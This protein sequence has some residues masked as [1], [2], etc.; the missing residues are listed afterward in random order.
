MFVSESNVFSLF[1]SPPHKETESMAIGEGICDVGVEENGNTSVDVTSSGTFSHWTLDFLAGLKW[2]LFL[3]Q[4]IRISIEVWIVRVFFKVI[5]GSWGLCYLQMLLAFFGR[6]AA[7]RAEK[8]LFWGF[9]FLF[10]RRRIWNS[11]YFFPLLGFVRMGV[12]AYLATELRIAWEQS[13]HNAVAGKQSLRGCR[14]ACCPAPEQ[15]TQVHTSE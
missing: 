11:C 8:R 10:L 13:F 1:F 9:C 6:V 15:S 3:G 12:G 7:G 14:E 2:S 4:Y 5:P